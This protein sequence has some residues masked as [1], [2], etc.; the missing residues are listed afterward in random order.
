[1]ATDNTERLLGT[2]SSDVK[3]ILLRQDKQD[4]RL[5][6]MDLRLNAVEKFQWKIMGIATFVPTALATMV[7]A[8]K[9]NPPT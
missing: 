3:H 2:I 7:V 9:L 1:M 8:L 6:R 4:S 5:D